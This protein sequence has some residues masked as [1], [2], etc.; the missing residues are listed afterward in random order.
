MSNSTFDSISSVL[1]TVLSVLGPIASAALPGAGVAIGIG[2]KIIAG[3][4]AAEPTAVALFN[5]IKNGTPAT[6]AQLQQFI[7]END[8]ANAKT[9]AD[10]D[11]ALSLLP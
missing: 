6:Q 5:Q 8:A 4:L 2:S 11:A 3:V 10:I 1:S 7:D 9:D